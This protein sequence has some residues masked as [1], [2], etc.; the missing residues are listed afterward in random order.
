MS[1]YVV[2]VTRENFSRLLPTILTSIEASDFY[3]IDTELTGLCSSKSHRYSSFDDLQARYLKVRDSA[4]NFGILQIGLSC[5]RW[6]RNKKKWDHTT[7]SFF[8][9]PDTSSTVSSNDKKFSCQISSINFL[10]QNGFDFNKSFKEGIPYLNHVEE[11]MF[12]ESSGLNE[13]EDSSKKSKNPIIELKNKDKEFM[14]G[15]C[16]LIDEW[17]K[18]EDINENLLLPSANSYQ[19]LLIHQQLDLNYKNLTAQKKFIDGK[20]FLY[21]SKLNNKEE[22]L[23]EKSRILDNLLGFRKVW[24]K[25]VSC[26]KPLIGH[27]CFLDLCQLYCKLV[28]PLPHEYD[29]FKSKLTSLFP[30]VYDTKY[31]CLTLSFFK[32]S[33]SNSLCDLFAYFKKNITDKL[34]SKAIDEVQF[35]NAG[36]DAYSTGAVFIYFNHFIRA[37]SCNVEE[38]SDIKET[39][40]KFCSELANRLNIMQS[41]YEYSNLLGVDPE[42]DWS[43]IVVLCFKD[44]DY[45]LSLTNKDIRE[46]IEQNQWGCS[47]SWNNNTS[48]FL[49][50]ESTEK[51]NK[52][53]DI[54]DI[55][56]DLITLESYRKCANEILREE[57]EQRKRLK[58]NN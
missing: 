47:Y 33:Q 26:G 19:R 45:A 48:I 57:N 43:K 34:I 7:F 30:V 41:P 13:G 24:D 9:F 49:S 22:R 3:A 12:R 53:K 39:E 25:L 14:D 27:N 4:V 46:I 32:E 50:F 2:E 21:L 42:P 17:L 8:V 55:H 16:K 10:S 23:E 5:F 52:V 56:Y 31:L 44:G 29:E 40:F 37:K 36:F 35:H 6:L 54:S 51:A 11:R 15:I 18:I 28:E 20:T 38:K 58:I 1:K